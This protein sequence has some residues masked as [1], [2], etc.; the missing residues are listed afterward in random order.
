MGRESLVEYVAGGERAV[1]KAHLDAL[2]MQ[3]SGGK[4]LTLPLAQVKS[5]VVDG[6]LLRIAAGTTKFSLKLGAKDAAAWANKILNPPSLADKLGFKAD[7]AVVLIGEVPGEIADAARA[8]KSVRTGKK[9]DGDIVAMQLS[10]GKE[11]AQIAAAA[12]A[13]G[14]STALWFVYAK[15]GAVNGDHIIALARKAGLKDT[16]VAR[17]SETHAALRFIR[18]K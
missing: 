11:G 15:G 10:A 8:A 16:K 18:G 17:V 4:K 7:K 12:R 9:F 13:L 3:L 5:A 14:D 2:N 6:D 1:V